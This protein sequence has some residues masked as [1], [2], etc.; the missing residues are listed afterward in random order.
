MTYMRVGL[1]PTGKVWGIWSGPPSPCAV[2][3]HIP[4]GFPC[5]LLTPGGRASLSVLL[6][7]FLL[8]VGPGGGGCALA[9]LPL[10]P[11]PL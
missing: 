3:S 2:M 10:H 8:L 11:L 7:L 4:S 1:S 6:L 9:A 5:V